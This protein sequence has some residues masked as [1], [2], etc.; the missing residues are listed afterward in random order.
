[1]ETAY[2]TGTGRSGIYA[3][4]IELEL[5]ES[6]SS[7]ARRLGRDKSTVSR[8]V[9]RNGTPVRDCHYRANRVRE[10]SDRRKRESH[11]RERIADGR[12]CK[13][14]EEK[15]T[16]EAWT[17]QR[18]AGRLELDLP[19]LPVSHETIYQ[20][21]YAE[22]RDLIKHLVCGHKERRKRSNS[23]KARIA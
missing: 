20:W 5:G 2:R 16:K 19:G 13:Y 9:R 18:I 23:R 6:Q 8:E 22:R 11:K 7:I 21:I 17:P 12:V 10:R 14:I 15:L 1:V 3:E 4:T